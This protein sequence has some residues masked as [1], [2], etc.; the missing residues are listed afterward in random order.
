MNHFAC[1]GLIA[2]HG[3]AARTTRPDPLIY[4]LTWTI[5]KLPFRISGASCGRSS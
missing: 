3:G 2:A 1:H 5:W 4:T